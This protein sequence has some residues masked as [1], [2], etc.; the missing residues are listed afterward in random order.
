MSDPIVLGREAGAVEG[1]CPCCGSTNYDGNDSGMEDDYYYYEQYCNDCGARWKDWYRL[2]FVEQEYWSAEQMREEEAANMEF[3]QRN[4]KSRNGEYHDK[5]V[6]CLDS[7]A[8]MLPNSTYNFLKKEIFNTTNQGFYDKYGYFS[9]YNFTARLRDI[10]GY[11]FDLQTCRPKPT[12]SE[13][14]TYIP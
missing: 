9:I 4:A 14:D 3:H 11:D 10:T 6:Q 2:D 12:T 7:V 13:L 8:G 1:Q 5:A